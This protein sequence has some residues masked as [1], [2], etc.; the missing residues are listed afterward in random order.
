MKI[1]LRSQLFG[2][3][4]ISINLLL[5]TAC[6]SV[7][8][9][10]NTNSTNL[11]TTVT[12]FT[13]PVITTESADDLVPIPAGFVEYRAQVE[14]NQFGKVETAVITFGAGANAFH[15][16]YRDYIETRP[17]ETRNNAFY[18]WQ[19]NNQGARQKICNVV[20]SSD[21]I[22]AGITVNMNSG[23]YD[24]FGVEWIQIMQISTFSNTQPFTYTFN[25]GIKIDGKDCGTIPCT[26]KV[27]S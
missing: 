19:Q 8:S 5:L 2:I 16:N 21:D 11:I 3:I 12:A 23:Y 6:N 25:I 17:G 22:P 15:V 26:L 13:S 24:N 4:C 14:P 18:I 20:L 7:K 10:S 27:T 1:N 9:S